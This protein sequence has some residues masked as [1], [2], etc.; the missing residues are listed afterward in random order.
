M[1]DDHVSSAVQSACALAGRKPISAMA[2]P[3]KKP[4][5]SIGIRSSLPPTLSGVFAALISALI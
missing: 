2:L 1:K 3:V 4:L 5:R